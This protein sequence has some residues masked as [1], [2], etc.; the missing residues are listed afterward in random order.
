MWCDPWHW[1]GDVP[2][3][4]CVRQACSFQTRLE[5][6]PMCRIV[7]CKPLCPQYPGL[8]TKTTRS[9]LCRLCS[10]VVMCKNRGI[11]QETLVSKPRGDFGAVNHMLCGSCQDKWLL[12]VKSLDRHMS[13]WALLTLKVVYELYGRRKFRSQTSDNMDRWKA[14]MGR[15]REEKRRRR[16]K[17]KE[18]K[19]RRKKMQAG[20]RKDR[21]VAKHCV[22]LMIWGSGSKSR[23]A[24][25]AG[26]EP[27]LARWEMKI[28]TP[29]WHEAHFEVKMYKA[30]QLRST[31]RSGDVE[32]VHA[33]VARSRFGSQKCKKLTGSEHFL[34]FRCHFTWQAQGILHVAKS[35]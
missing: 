3:L 1:L 18:E 9:T 20:A 23:L 19:V 22:F 32:K 21:K 5:V 33:V 26:A 28:C 12:C 24:K 34:T 25:A 16:K 14:E 4:Y 31:F 29:L 35:E 27:H 15:V 6:N 8:K 17:I 10:C 2:S 7:V 30:P 13:C 11:P